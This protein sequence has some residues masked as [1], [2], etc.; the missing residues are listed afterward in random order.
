ME[1]I[2]A[3]MQKEETPPPVAPHAPAH[4]IQQPNSLIGV[5]DLSNNIADIKRGPRPVS[6]VSLRQSGL[7]APS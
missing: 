3:Q 2:K 7:A 5:H 1:V 4:G 6:N